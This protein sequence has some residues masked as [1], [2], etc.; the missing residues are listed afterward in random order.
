MRREGPDKGNA[1]LDFHLGRLTRLADMG[2]RHFHELAGYLLHRGGR[3]IE[4]GRSLVSRS[5][6]ELPESRLRCLHAALDLS[7][8][9]R[10]NGKGNAAG[11]RVPDRKLSVLRS[12]QSRST[13]ITRG[14]FLPFR[15]EL[16]CKPAR[17]IGFG[18]TCSGHDSPSPAHDF[19]IMARAR[20]A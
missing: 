18:K 11:P 2:N 17:R 1:A 5:P 3:T 4:P 6:D 8:T 20:E 9:T 7:R 14:H 19:G 15:L 16:T 10:T 13:D 12:G